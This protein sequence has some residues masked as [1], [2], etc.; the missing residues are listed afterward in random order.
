M[1]KFYVY[2]YLN[3]LKKG[4][5]IFKD[6]IFDYAPFYIGKGCGDRYKVHLRESSK[7]INRYKDNTIQQIKRE[8][9][10]SPIIKL[11]YEQLEENEALVIEQEM[12]NHFGR[13]ILYPNWGILTNMTDGGGGT[14][15]TIHAPRTKEW[16]EKQRQ[17]HLGNKFSDGVK[18]RLSEMRM[19]D[20][21][22][23]YGNTTPLE[24]R[25]KIS[26]GLKRSSDKIKYN[27]LVN[28]YK[29]LAK[30]ITCISP[31]NIKTIFIDAPKGSDIAKFLA[32]NKLAHGTVQNLIKANKSGIQL[33]LGKAKGWTFIIEEPTQEQIKEIISQI[34]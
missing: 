26:E 15:G 5:Y 6:Y 28:K 23:N 1:N 34:K 8:L 20:K 18:Q 27:C 29:K 21:H 14:S 7:N 2:V 25:N 13:K 4:K 31:D 11:V 12:I 22:W 33:S 16:K 3:P 19:G 30:V 24:T 17:S 10:I 32:D 9:N